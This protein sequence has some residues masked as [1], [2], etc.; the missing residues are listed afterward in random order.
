MVIAFAAWT[1]GVSR[2]ATR[3]LGR[4]AR[5]LYQARFGI[6]TAYRQK[7]QA[8]AVTTSRSPTDRLLLEGLAHLIRQAWVL[9]TAQLAR[10]SPHRPSDWVGELR[11]ATLLRWLDDALRDG[12]AEI[13]TISLNHAS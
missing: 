3:S 9:L 5:R 11:L 2:P 6:E 4:Q 7:N 8:R 13:R 1:N 10:R 12:L